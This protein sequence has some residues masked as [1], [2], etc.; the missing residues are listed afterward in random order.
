MRY[1]IQ[2]LWNP[3]TSIQA[4]RGPKIKCAH[5]KNVCLEIAEEYKF[6]KSNKLSG[7]SSPLC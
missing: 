3:V 7:E 5:L 2:I 1:K 4:I 6:T